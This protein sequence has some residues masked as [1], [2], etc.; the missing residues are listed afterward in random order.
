[1]RNTLRLLRST[2]LAPRVSFKLKHTGT[3][4]A[5]ADVAGGCRLAEVL[6]LRY[7]TE[8]TELL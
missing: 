7:C 5:L 4:R 2:R 1:V 6:V 3:E 8:I